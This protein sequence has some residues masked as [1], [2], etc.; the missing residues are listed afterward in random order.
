MGL[1]KCLLEGGNSKPS[2]LFGKNKVNQSRGMTLKVC[3]VNVGGTE[4]LYKL[5]LKVPKDLVLM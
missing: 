3:I 2:N 4:R 1:L 5:D